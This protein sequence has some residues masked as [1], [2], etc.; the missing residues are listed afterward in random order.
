MVVDFWKKHYSASR[1]TL[2]VQSNQPTHEMVKLIDDL[3]GKIPT[4]NKPAPKFKAHD[5]PFYQDLFHQIFKVVSVSST[6]KIIFLWHLPSIIKFYKIKPL[7]YISWVV[8]HEG[9]GMLINYLRKLNYALELEAGVED[10]FCNNSIYSIFSLGIELTDLGFENVDRVIEL[11]FG[12]LNLVRKNGVSEHI[13]KQIQILAQSNFDFA[14]SK[15]AIDHVT[16]L[17]ENMLL[18]D[19]EDYLSGPSLYSEYSEETIKIF[20]NLISAKRVS[21]FI[22]AKTFDNSDVFTEDPI[23][24][25]KYLTE[26]I[27]ED[28]ENKWSTMKPHPF[29]KIEVENQFLTT[30]FSILPLDVDTKYPEKIFENDCIEL[31]YKQDNNFKLP[32]SYVMF[33]FISALSSKS[34]DNYLCLKLLFDSLKFLISEDTYPAVMAQ[35]N[36]SIEV[37][38]N[39]FELSFNGFNEKLPMLIDIVINSLN[40]FK[41]LMTED[42]FEMIKSKA[43]NKLKN[44]TYN[45][46]Y[47]STD[48][49]NS[50]I[51][52]TYWNV[53]K[54]LLCLENLTYKQLLTFYEQFKHLYCRTL[55]QGNI[56]Q[57]Q[58]IDITKKVVSILNYKPLAKECFPVFSV[59]RL[60]QGDYRV[61]LQNY[62]PNDNNSM[63]YKY[64]QFDKSEIQN[65]VKYQIL[66]AI[67]EES[68]FNELRTHLCLGYDVQLN[69]TDA[70][71]RYGFCFIVAHQEKKFETQF[72][73]DRMDD[74]LESFWDTFNKP[75]KVNNVRDALIALKEAPDDSLEQEFD[76]YKNEI[77]RE[78]FKFDILE[79]EIEA[80]KKLTFDDVKNLKDG[81][82]GGRS[83]SVE[84]VG[85]DTDDAVD[86]SPPPTKR[87][88]LRQDKNYVLIENLDEF[89]NSL[90]SY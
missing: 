90:N 58:A 42:I 64:Y 86:D 41:S 48:L 26:T 14:E 17:S 47:V 57:N 34:V 78:R 83:F 43:I 35:L 69:L 68:A 3:F 21:I 66:Q 38:M 24:E 20:L 6:K 13:F 73:F 52:D 70:Y 84:I 37:F 65:T 63:A 76:K 87:V 27:T 29:F 75:I 22:S 31:W 30:D 82:I 62:N 50:L 61:K 55:I 1:M 2:A 9:K 4:D 51:E 72:I 7:E 33:Y 8:G 59:K 19:E 88:C 5:D 71:E 18:Y 53:N 46:D 49:K 32:K 54:R 11:T 12:F 10:D 39:G 74:F 25:T 85:N 23:F 79:I 28:M 56:N 44:G 16:E 40:N 45:L 36:Y 15:K 77:I 67:I 80:L 60:N 89:K 81:F